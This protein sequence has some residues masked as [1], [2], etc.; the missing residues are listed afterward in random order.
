[1]HTYIF[2]V[3]F[4]L[5]LPFFQV[6]IGGA[7]IN[8]PKNITV[9]AVIMFGDSI[10]D[11][12]NNNRR[13][14]AIKANYLPYGQDFMGGKPTGRFPNGK[15]PSGFLGIYKHTHTLLGV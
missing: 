15:V 14:T 11:T 4:A 10:V 6:C 9:P 8:L 5:S 3:C 2:F 13:K 12:G 1:M 7:I